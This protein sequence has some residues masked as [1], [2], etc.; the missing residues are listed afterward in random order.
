MISMPA[1]LVTRSH[2][3]PAV[4]QICSP[5]GSPLNF[6][7]LPDGTLVF[8]SL[9]GTATDSNTLLQTVFDGTVASEFTGESYQNLLGTLGTDG[10]L[11]ASY[12]TEIAA[13]PF[14]Q[15][16]SVPEPGPLA[17]FGLGLAAIGLARRGR[18]VEA[19]H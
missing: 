9:E 19:L 13:G 7:N 14:S 16:K 15:G 1:F 8:Y 12:S 5:V 3:A 11:S 10:T 17:L 4:G 18:R 2:L 6:V